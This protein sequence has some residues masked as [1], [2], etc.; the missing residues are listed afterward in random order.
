MVAG[1]KKRSVGF[2]GLGNAGLPMAQRLLDAGYPLVVYDLRPEAMQPLVKKGARKAVSSRQTVQEITITVVP[3]PKEVEEVYYGS[4]GV[5][6][7][8]KEGNFVIEASGID[9]DTTLHLAREVSLRGAKF[10]AATVH[11]AGAPAVTIPQGLLTLV[12]GGE[13][14]TMKECQELLQTLAQTVVFVPGVSTPKLLKIAIIMLAV[15]RQAVAGEVVFWLKRCGAD[16]QW[17]IQLIEETERL[18]PAR[19]LKLITGGGLKQGG[20]I[21]NTHKDLTLALKL[22]AERDLPLPLTACAQQ[23]LQSAK[24]AGLAG[25]DLPE[26]LLE[27]YKRLLREDLP[28]VPLDLKEHMPEPHR[29]RVRWLGWC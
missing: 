9:P 23:V 21:R 11:A 29:P 3:S 7:G 26:S 6:A 1:K 17:L 19:E 12:V 8:L 2:I 16:P 27:L 28:L 4:S 20:N 24:G 14:A 18:T 13:K 15:V 5:L 22:A 10:L 25:T